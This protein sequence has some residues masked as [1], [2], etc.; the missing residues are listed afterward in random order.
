MAAQIE[1]ASRF[2][3]RSGLDGFDEFTADSGRKMID[4]RKRRK[5]NGHI[6]RGYSF[7]I[8]AG[9]AHKDVPIVLEGVGFD[10][11]PLTCDRN[12][13]QSIVE[14]RGVSE[15]R[16]R[17]I[18]C[19]GRLICSSCRLWPQGQ[20]MAGEWR[21]GFS[22]FQRMCCRLGKGRSIRLCTGSNTRR[23]LHRTGELQRTIGERSTTG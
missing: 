13:E 14:R 2:A 20:C 4:A 18:F 9:L 23:G 22:W 5:R 7:M 12:R 1:S 10:L 21:S 16:N 11:F 8:L 3:C 19:R 6:H 17:P 15:C